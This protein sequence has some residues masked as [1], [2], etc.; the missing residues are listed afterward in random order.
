MPCCSVEASQLSF[1]CTAANVTFWG[2]CAGAVKP[3]H[4]VCSSGVVLGYS[5]LGMLAAARW[6]LNQVKP[7]LKQALAQHPDY[8]LRI[9]GE[10]FTSQA[11][12]AWR[13]VPRSI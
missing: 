4:L 5:H 12:N 7:V 13:L 2:L 10:F 1:G 8:E 11:R 9:V 3:H 6:M